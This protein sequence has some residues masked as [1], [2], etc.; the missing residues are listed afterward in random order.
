MF[1]ST[2]ISANEILFQIFVFLKKRKAKNLD[3]KGKVRKRFH[4][5]FCRKQT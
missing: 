1:L 4:A 5:D 2:I 3:R